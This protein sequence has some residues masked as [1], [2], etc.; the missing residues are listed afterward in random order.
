[1]YQKRGQGFTSYSEKS[2]V[3]KY[4]KCQVSAAGKFQ[5]W[6]CFQQCRPYS[7]ICWTY[8]IFPIIN[9]WEWKTKWNYLEK[10]TVYTWFDFHKTSQVE[11]KLKLKISALEISLF[12][13]P[14]HCNTVA[15]KRRSTSEIKITS[16]GKILT[17]VVGKSQV[18]FRCHSLDMATGL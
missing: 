7:L 3:P 13:L 12:V 5:T 6:T 11:I 15:K 8:C 2:C 1:M 18:C 16:L 9:S 17:Q 10:L 14:L 4:V